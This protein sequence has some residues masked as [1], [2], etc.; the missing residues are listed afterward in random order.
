MDRRS[1]LG[2]AL[3]AFAAPA[4]VRAASLMPVRAL[5]PDWWV[6]E[7]WIIPRGQILS[8]ARYAPLFSAIG[9]AYGGD[10]ETFRLP[11]F[12]PSIEYPANVQPIIPI[13]ATKEVGIM[14]AGSIVY[15]A[16]P[17][18]TVRPAQPG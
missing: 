10:A 18:L 7:G 3:A 9:H 15:Y 11:D 13:I 4:I 14:S 17:R 5:D 6:P 1:F 8:R 12:A 16:P 2:G